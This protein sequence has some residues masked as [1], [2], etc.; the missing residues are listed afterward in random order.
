MTFEFNSFSAD[1]SRNVNHKMCYLYHTYSIRDSVD[2]IP[3]SV[4]TS[5]TSET[6]KQLKTLKL[7]LMDRI[8]TIDIAR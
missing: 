3:T 4:S 8:A 7:N 6:V 1:T 5:C 2:Y